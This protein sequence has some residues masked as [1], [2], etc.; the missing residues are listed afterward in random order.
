MRLLEV[1][2]VDVAQQPI[3]GVGVWQGVD[4]RE[5]PPQ[6]LPSRTRGVARNCGRVISRLVSRR[7]AN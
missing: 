4:L 5:Q 1:G 7:E 3:E 6:S 2:Q